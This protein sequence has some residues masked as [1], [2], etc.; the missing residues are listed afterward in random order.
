M[1]APLAFNK[2]PLFADD[3]VRRV[4]N[5]RSEE[6]LGTVIG[7]PSYRNVDVQWPR[8][9]GHHQPNQLIKIKESTDVEDNDRGIR[10]DAGGSGRGDAGADA[11]HGEEGEARFSGS[12]EGDQHRAERQARSQQ[13]EERQN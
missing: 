3:R 9:I 5:S 6:T 7:K 11:L 13:Q 1:K 2:K 4:G 8:G 12:G 10:P